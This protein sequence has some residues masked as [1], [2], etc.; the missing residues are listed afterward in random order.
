MTTS[1]Q[2]LPWVRTALE[3]VEQKLSAELAR[4][5]SNIPYMSTT[6]VYDYKNSREKIHSWTN[7]F[8]PGMLWEMFVL[9]KDPSFKDAACG[10][11]DRLDEAFDEFVSINHDTGFV[12]S[13]SSVAHYRITGNEQ[14]RTRAL[15]AATI[16]A[17]RFNPAGNFISAFNGDQSGWVIIDTML[18]LPLLYWASEQTGDPRFAKIAT[19]HAQ[20]TMKSHLREDGS[21]KHV[22]VFDTE[23]GHPIETLA[24]QGYLPTTSWTRGQA[25]AVYGFALAYKYTGKKEFLEASQR[26]AAYIISEA[27]KLDDIFPCDF[28]QPD[29]KEALD[30]S[31]TCAVASGLLELAQY[32]SEDLASTYRKNAE[33]F[34]HWVLNSHCNWDPDYDGIV[35]DSTVAY[36][37]VRNVHLIYADF[38]LLEALLKL[39]G[40]GVFLW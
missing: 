40:E 14:S 24:G 17:G 2:T 27:N 8:W 13:L 31:A 36:E 39:T 37:T 16:L 1:A 5:G 15:H 25:W 7:G 11:E 26:S 32:S 34:L 21:T 38:Y 19:L 3:N 23:T 18:N 33:K 20:T 4:I 28:G 6:G 9:T 12:W 30:A 29:Y 35:Q 10:C 22:V